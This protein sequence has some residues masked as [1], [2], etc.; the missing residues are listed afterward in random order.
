MDASGRSM[1]AWL[2]IVA[3]MIG[4]R[5]AWCM[6]RGAVSSA[7][8]YS[9]LLQQ[10]DA[11]KSF[12]GGKEAPKGRYTY[13]VSL[14][15]PRHR[16][17]GCGG[18]L[19]A[20]KWV[21]TAAHCV[22]P[23][24][25][26]SVGPNPVVY[27]GGHNINDDYSVPGV[28]V[29]A[30]ITTIIHEDFDGNVTHGSDIALLELEA[31]SSKE[32]PRLPSPLLE[33]QQ[34]ENLVAVGWGAALV[35]EE[36]K[37]LNH[38]SA[39]TFVPRKN[40]NFKQLWNGLIRKSMVCAGGTHQDTCKGDSGGPLLIADQPDGK[41][42]AGKARF[43][44]LVGITSF[45]PAKCLTFS[46]PGVYTSVPFYVDWILAHIG[47][48]VST[49]N[50]FESTKS[51]KQT[52]HT[53]K[54]VEDFKEA[55][56]ND[57]DNNRRT[58]ASDSGKKDGKVPS[59]EQF[60]Q[61]TPT[62]RKDIDESTGGSTA[63]KSDVESKK[64]DKGK[65]PK[66]SSKG[67]KPSQQRIAEQDSENGGAKS[68]V[69]RKK[70]NAGASSRKQIEKPPTGR[71][72]NDDGNDGGDKTGDN[73]GGQ[74]ADDGRKSSTKRVSK[75][76]VK[77]P[78]S[79]RR[80]NDDSDSSDDNGDGDG[81]GGGSSGGGSDSGDDNGDGVGGKAA[82]DRKKMGTKVSSEKPTK[83]TS[84]T[85]RKNDEADGESSNGKTADDSKR[86]ETK[87]SSEN[88]PNERTKKDPSTRRKKAQQDSACCD[89]KGTADNGKKSTKTSSKM[90][91]KRAPHNQRKSAD[92][93]G[94]QNGA[95]KKKTKRTR[96]AA[97]TAVKS[98]IQIKS[99]SVG[100]S[101]AENA[102]STQQGN[103][104]V[105]AFSSTVSHQNLP[106][107]SST[108]PR[109]SSSPISEEGS[110]SD[111]EAP[112]SVTFDVWSANPTEDPPAMP[113]Q[114]DHPSE[115]APMPVESPVSSSGNAEDSL[116]STLLY[117]AV[118]VGDLQAVISILRKGKSGVNELSV[119]G[120]A[121]LHVAAT[122]GWKDIVEELIFA[123]AD[124]NV[125]TLFTLQTPLHKA[126]VADQLLIVECLVKNGAILDAVDSYGR[127]PLLEATRNMFAS[128]ALHL[129]SSN[130]DLTVQDVFGMNALHYAA[131]NGDVK[132]IQVLVN[133]GVDTT[134][135]NHAGLT[136]EEM[137]CMCMHTCSS[138]C[139]TSKEA[140]QGALVG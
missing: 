136:A 5:M 2:A 86:K 127:T 75:S 106:N 26:F 41:I 56:E 60:K 30:T 98:Q 39:L 43:D 90:S 72:K 71:R 3:L 18:M 95:E 15:T 38:A 100:G 54:K 111:N 115:T 138:Y 37:N 46:K 139:L 63:D 13:I 14:R 25:D 31:E 11:G 83:I 117:E 27:I 16:L 20:P 93:D 94:K 58:V 109:D 112:P 121:P 40:C 35:G 104:T 42:K 51:T 91:T 67:A 128:V 132:M 10:L 113:L 82:G 129:I 124:V 1:S 34:G 107:D 4:G 62:R 28:E 74:T 19:I 80:K 135:R 89:A 76:P 49:F 102:P 84:P 57:T 52:V 131:Q 70:Q 48:P 79:S 32:F 73:S 140:V 133:N 8:T 88:S 12:T 9:R 66:K 65:S 53:S 29:M 97:P 77:V 123:G 125:R 24:I 22:D 78:S 122:N 69:D 61:G 118:K 103:A 110:F 68:A 21:L 45:G 64:K 36:P 101:A 134:I 114:G 108:V 33:L 105:V 47:G 126:V 59:K 87:K 81:D 99:K 92:G 137:V 6:S 116:N 85:R 23:R 7:A 44:L 130:A 55:A 119:E 17:H 96:K 120:T 50:K